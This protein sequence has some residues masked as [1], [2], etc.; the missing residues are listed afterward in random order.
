VPTE[1]TEDTAETMSDKPPAD[2][3]AAELLSAAELFAVSQEIATFFPQPF[4]RTRVVLM[5]V[6]PHHVHAYWHIRMDDIERAREQVGEGADSAPLVLRFYDV[7]MIDFSRQPAHGQFDVAVHG[8]VNNWYVDLWADGRSYVADIGLRRPDG[9]LVALARSNFVHTPPAG[10]AAYCGRGALLL[11][12]DGSVR[13]VDISTPAPAG[14]WPMRPTPQTPPDQT[15]LLVRRFYRRL[16][17]SGPPGSLD[18]SGGH[19]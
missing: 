9:S 10:Q 14:P 17:D 15:E 5:V 18:S 19:V 16:V 12:R 4:R 6:D 7:T 13:E 2:A 11:E 3:P 1:G 8:L